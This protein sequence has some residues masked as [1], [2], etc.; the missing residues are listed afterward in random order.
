MW[1]LAAAATI[2][3]AAVVAAAATAA[4]AE[5]DE[6]IS[7]IQRQEFPP[8]QLLPHINVLHSAAVHRLIL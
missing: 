7:M 6:R 8:K 1:K 4:A 5:E 3:V 2:V